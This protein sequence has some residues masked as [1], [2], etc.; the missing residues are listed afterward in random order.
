MIARKSPS[1][2]VL[3][4]MLAV[5]TSLAC[6]DRHV[7]HHYYPA[8]NPPSYAAQPAAATVATNVGEE[9]LDPT[10][11]L[12]LFK[13]C[14]NA[15]ELEAK[16][17]SPG[18]INNL[19]LDK[20]GNVD[21]IRVTE[22]GDPSQRCLSLTAILANGNEQEVATLQMQGV[23]GGYDTQYIG[24]ANV[25]GPGYVYRSHFSLGEAL[26]LAW[27]FTPSH[28][29]YV[30]PYHYGYYP[31]TYIRYRMV[32]A[33]QYRTVTRTYS[34]AVR[35]ERIQ[36]PTIQPR[37]VSPNQGKVIPNLPVRQ[38]QTLQQPALTGAQK[39]QVPMQTRDAN[40]PVGT[41]GFGTPA[42]PQR[43]VVTQPA[44]RQGPPAGVAP[45]QTQNAQAARQAPAV[46]P[47]PSFGRRK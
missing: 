22:Y 42:A 47:A 28:R 16:L 29:I 4:L 46:R 44:V 10:A 31:R 11:V 12:A 13:T 45:K 23:N 17:N 9:M 8:A 3:F 20:D 24:H 21:Y 19:D 43:P 34:T 38:T 41:G 33:T 35:T 40:K 14:R 15:E 7:V 1:F 39:S 36:Q 37:A 30:S 18:S 2:V 6:G 32:P 27:L 25:Y 5:L 26:F